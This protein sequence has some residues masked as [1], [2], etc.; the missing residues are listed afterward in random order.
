[1]AKTLLTGASGFIGSHVARALAGRGDELRVMARRTADLGHLDDLDLERVGGDITDRRAVRRAVAGVERVFHMAG[2][3]SMRARDSER[4]FDVNVRGSQIV[5]EESLRE[6]VERVVHT[7]SVVA[8]GPARPHGAA[9]ESQLFRGGSLGITYVNSKREAEAQG[10]RLA[11]KGLPIVFVNPA[12]VIGPDDPN[13]TSMSLI[14]RFLLRQIPVYVDGALNIVDV[15]DVATGHLLADEHGEV[16]ERYIL[17]GRN[18]T[19]DRLFADL[20]R[21]SGVAP[22]PLRLPAGMAL[23]AVEAADRAG[24]GMPTSPDEARSASQWWTYRNAKARRELGFRPR[25]HEQTLEDAV[26]WQQ[27]NLRGRTPRRSVPEELALKAV[28]RLIRTGEA[29]LSR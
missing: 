2:Q 25:P 27:A 14:R 13:G 3:T 12:F 24:I 29:L 1:M 20:A 17:G 26:A 8:V 15:R 23:L 6:E 22:P 28:S 10:L 21:I 19:L 9:E 5:F 18:F 11:A 16:G 7:S 4:V